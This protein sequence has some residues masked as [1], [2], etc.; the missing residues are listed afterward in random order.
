MFPL[1]PARYALYCGVMAAFALTPGPANLFMIATG[2][3]AGPRNVLLGVAGLNLASLVWLIG[4]ALGLGALTV[5][6]PLAFRFMAIAGAAYVAWLGAKSLWS[7]ATGEV[8]HFEEIKATGPVTA[9]RDGF[10]VQISNPKA[11]VFVAAVLPPF[12]DP[13]RPALIQIAILGATMMLMDV[14]TMTSYGL[15]G[16]ALSSVLRAQAARRAFAV[17]TGVLLIA[18]ALFIALRH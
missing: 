12:V 10:V 15:A 1:D 8:S 18:A 3:R 4:A 14:V 5:A 13:A 9:F 11:M 17:F 6:F 2:V 7:A 16:G